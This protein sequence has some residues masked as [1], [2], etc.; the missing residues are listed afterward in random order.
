MLIDAKPTICSGF[1]IS[2]EAFKQFVED[3]Q[4]F[5]VEDDDI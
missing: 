5:E 3:M 4:L 1:T 2:P